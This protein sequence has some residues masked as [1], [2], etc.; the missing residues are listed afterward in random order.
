ML[1]PGA[2]PAI[3]G[4]FGSC[5][6][7]V[8]H[9]TVSTV[10]A[11]CQSRRHVRQRQLKAEAPT[12]EGE[13]C[14]SGRAHALSRIRTQIKGSVHVTSAQRSHIRTMPFSSSHNCSPCKLPKGKRQAQRS[15]HR[16][17]GFGEALVSRKPRLCGPGRGLKKRSAAQSPCVLCWKGRPG[18]SA[19]ART[20]RQRLQ[21]GASEILGASCRSGHR[22]AQR[23]PLHHGRTL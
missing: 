22:Q 13:N 23:R 16:L 5:K 21:C 19:E 4:A 8:C 20:S 1:L 15:S 7:A 17:Q 6:V 14:E 12:G 11:V 18:R 10:S 2:G 9:C 3:P